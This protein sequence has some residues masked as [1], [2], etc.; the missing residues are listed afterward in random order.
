MPDVSNTWDSSTVDFE[1][2]ALSYEDDA[3]ETPGAIT[4]EYAR[5]AISVDNKA[6]FVT[7][8]VIG[9]ST[10]RQKIGE[11]PRELSI[12]GVVVESTAVDLDSLRDAKEGKIFCN[13][14]PGDSMNAQFA[15]VSTS[16]L[17]DGGAG[18]LKD[19]EFLYNF[20]LKALEVNE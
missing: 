6:R 11:E 10:V 19:G 14:L 8:E 2:S 1:I 9:G 18:R 3:E 12:K 15:S 5:P 17:E 20:K 16:P 13:R 4:F 7:H